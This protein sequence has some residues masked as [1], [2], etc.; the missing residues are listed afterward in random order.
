MNKNMKNILILSLFVMFLAGCDS[1]LDVTPKTDLTDINFW[2]TETHFKG[3]S[4]QLYNQLPNKEH[5]FRGDDMFTQGT[6]N[7]GNVISAGRWSL[8]ATDNSNWRDPYRAI[9]NANN[10][11]EN[12]PNSP[13]SERLRNRYLG[14]AL[15]FRAWWHFELVCKYGDV[16]LVL[17][18][19]QETQDPDLKM[20]RTPRE[21][22]IRQC[23][24]DLRQA[25]RY[26]ITRAELENNT[27]E[28]DRRRATRSSALGLMVRIG[29]HEG[30][31]GKYHNLGNNWQAHLD[32]CIRVF[33]QLSAEGHEL[34]TGD[35]A[36][37]YLG[38]LYEE[39]NHLN[40]ETIFGKAHGPNGSTGTT[41]TW[42][43]NYSAN[44][45]EGSGVTRYMIDMYLYAD[46][47][48]G[49]KSAYYL[50]PQDEISYNS[51]FG[52]QYVGDLSDGDGS[53]S[54]GHPRDPRMTLTF[55]REWD[56]D[57]DPNLKISGLQIAWRMRRGER[58]NHYYNTTRH[59]PA[60]KL[61]K[62]HVGQFGNP[63]GSDN[64]DHILIRYG[65]MLIAYAEALYERNGS[66]TDAQLDETVNA[67]RARAGFN[68]KLTN[69]FVTENGLNMLEEI[70]RER[71]VELMCEGRR[72]TD[73]IR[74]KI[75]EH[76]LP[77]GVVANHHFNNEAVEPPTS[78]V[79][80]LSVTDENG[81]LDGV[82]EY[83][84]PNMWV[85]ERSTV[86]SF[87]PERDYYYWIPTNEIVKSDG[88][89]R[90]NPNW[91]VD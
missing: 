50:A 22:V 14:E 75:A 19:F 69:A 78:Q 37:A 48:P 16:P 66:I 54:N 42:N 81:L 10:I 64:N 46:G 1:M 89:I 25:S 18:T 20:G 65:E 70:R 29:L 5:D 30:T 85:W 55:W 17:K 2:L 88:N 45:Q 11:I 87:R 74:W 71:T 63:G 21:D 41:G 56:P 86:R 26:M 67:L 84:A 34:Y 80:Q 4:N 39:R 38:M 43:T 6:T 3:A 9:A 40:K 83:P 44:C 59:E 35:G 36:Y 27:N 60:Y 91:S 13:L 24:A 47:L 53:I 90:Q 57:D 68:V 31:M 33:T 12:A 62:G 7:S 51:V 52:Y 72:Y 73:I 77:K 32:T 8:S 23:Y 79:L 49:E 82:L 61:K 15:F 76:V 58:Y 28:I